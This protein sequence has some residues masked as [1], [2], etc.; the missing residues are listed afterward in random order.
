MSLIKTLLTEITDAKKEALRKIYNKIYYNLTDSDIEKYVSE[1]GVPDQFQKYYHQF[2]AKKDASFE[3]ILTL[4]P[5]SN[6]TYTQ[7]LITKGIPSKYTTDARLYK[8]YISIAQTLAEDAPRITEYLETFDM[9]KK[10]KDF[11]IKDINQ[12]KTIMDLGK[13]MKPYITDPSEDMDKFIKEKLELPLYKNSIEIFYEDDN[14]IVAEPK[15]EYGGCVLGADSVWCTS[16]GKYSFKEKL[17][18]R[19]NL[20]NTYNFNDSDFANRIISFINKNDN[21]HYQIQLSKKQIMDEDDSP[22]RVDDF[23]EFLENISPNAYKW[24]IDNLKTSNILKNIIY[25]T[26]IGYSEEEKDGKIY[27]KFKDEADFIEDYVPDSRWYVQKIRDGYIDMDYSPDLSSYD[28]WNSETISKINLLTISPEEKFY[29][30]NSL[31]CLKDFSL[32]K[33]T[34]EDHLNKE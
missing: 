18:S 16:W 1:N 26:K 24:L 22:T 5:T 4:D 8:S 9:M 32:C 20:F 13:L 7:W 19:E 12:V 17:K 2:F 23:T 11:P 28:R 30:T 25:N 29:Y 14:I 15:N 10:K 27:R 33:K 21:N 3:L 31:S 34:F 6:N